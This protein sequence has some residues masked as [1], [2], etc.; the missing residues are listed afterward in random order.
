MK[1]I[2]EETL[3]GGNEAA[4]TPLRRLYTSLIDYRCI[5][6]VIKNG[7]TSRNFYIVSSPE[8]IPGYKESRNGKRLECV[9]SF[10]E[11]NNWHVTIN[12]ENGWLI[13]TSEELPLEKSY[14]NNFEQLAKWINS[15]IH[16][17]LPA[18]D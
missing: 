8:Q 11:A 3:G 16:A 17:S 1:T 13:F 5:V 10:A 12:S 18:A 15:S 2:K 9:Q 4:T 6:Q 14:E 7:I